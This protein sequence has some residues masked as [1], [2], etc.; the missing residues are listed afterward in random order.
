MT[1]IIWT[2]VILRYIFSIGLPWAEEIAKYLLVWSAMI[3]AAIVLFEKGHISVNFLYD[4]FSNK[5]KKWIKLA[6][7]LIY[8]CFFAIITYYGYFYA[9]FGMRFTSPST[10]IPR[11]WPYLS[12][13]IGGLFMTCFSIVML[14]N[15]I[16]NRFLKKGKSYSC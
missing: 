10:G 3:G 15:H 6:H 2:Q 4:K 8:I 13:F 11:F 5:Y 16:Y 14:I 12:I 9:I 1:I 7:Y